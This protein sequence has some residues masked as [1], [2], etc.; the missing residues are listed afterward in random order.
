MDDYLKP[1]SPN[2]TFKAWLAGFI[3]GDGHIA[4]QGKSRQIRVTITNTN[5]DVLVLIQTVYGG[6]LKEQYNSK[7]PNW[8]T[9]YHL[10][11]VSRK[12][13]PLL[14]DILPYLILK[15]QHAKLCLMINSIQF[16]ILKNHNHIPQ[17]ESAQREKEAL[18]SELAI[19]NKRGL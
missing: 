6:T 16:K 5:K 13:L 18:S 8:K 3:D 15:H 2:E 19:L 7:H 4:T 10:C 17:I 12:A 11:F 9:G 1:S 14:Q